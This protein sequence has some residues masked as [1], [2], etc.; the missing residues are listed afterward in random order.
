MLTKTG[1]Y[2]TSLG[3]LN[4]DVKIIIVESPFMGNH[5]IPLPPFTTKTP[6]HFLGEWQEGSEVALCQ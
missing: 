6:L 1:C 4:S 2:E 5:K 3:K